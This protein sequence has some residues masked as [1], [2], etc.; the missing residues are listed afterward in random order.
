MDIELSEEACTLGLVKELLD[1]R[2]WVLVFDSSFIKLLIVL[3]RSQF[4]I[5]FLYKEERGSHG[6][7]GWSDSSS[8]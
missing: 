7:L 6:G 2:Q 8:A 1:K 3:Y 4:P 5:L